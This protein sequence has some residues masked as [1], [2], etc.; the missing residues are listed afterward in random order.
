MADSQKQHPLLSALADGQFILGTFAS[1]CSSGMSV[2]TIPERWDNT[3]E[4]NLALAHLLDDAG[5][6]FMLPI[7]RWIGYGGATNF[8]GSVLEAMT[9]AAGLLAHT[10]R[11]SVISTVHT[12]ANNPVVAAKQ[13]VTL[14][15]ISG[16]R[17]GLNIVAG[18]NQPEYEALGL[19]LPATHEARYAYAQE[20]FDVVRKL[21]ASDAPFDWDGKF[22]K[23]K[24]VLGEPRLAS[25]A[26]VPILNAAGSGEGRAFA[27]RNADLLF[28]PAVDLQRSVQEVADIKAQ[29][30]EIGRTVGVVTFSHVVCRPT[31][32]EAKEFFEYFCEKNTDS[33]AVNNLVALQFAH[34]QSF[35][36]DLLEKI[37]L[38]MAAG[39]G[40]YLLVGTP[41]QV[42]DVCG[43]LHVSLSI[44]NLST[45]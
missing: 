39:H 21:W 20:W 38:R 37:R 13:L 4:N 26:S 43:I 36:H 28:T 9:W 34:A 1:N 18:W 40:G 41:R 17:A 33:E 25:P 5:V 11:L 29:G 19:E 8:H 12:T 30:R 14:D 32:Q 24:N 16:G 44:W 23:L 2:T 27:V 6:E 31:E 35:P 22:W 7:A 3:W 42:A 45:G 15:R 10:R